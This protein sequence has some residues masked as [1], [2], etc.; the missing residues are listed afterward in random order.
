MNGLASQIFLMCIPFFIKVAFWFVWRSWRSTV[1]LGFMVSVAVA[2]LVFLS[3]LAVGTNDAMVRNS[4]GLYSGHISAERLSHGLSRES[5]LVSGVK[6]VLIRNSVQ[7]W[8]GHGHSREATVL[9]GVDPTE[10]RRFT[11]LW[12]K[13]SRGRYLRKEDRA[14]F[15]SEN[16]AHRLGVGVGARVKVGTV[17]GEWIGSLTVCGL[18]RTG[19][20]ALDLGMAFCTMDTLP[21]G[22]GHPSAAVFLQDGVGPDAVLEK[23]GSL[24]GSSAF[25][26]WTEFMPDLK[27]L[28]DL[29]YLSMGIVMVLVFGV[30]SLGISCA[31]V[32]FI[33]KS[34]REH[35]I[36]KAMGVL[37]AESSCMIAAQILLLTLTASLAGVIVGALAVAGFSR[38]GIDLGAWTSYNPYLAVSGVIFPRLTAYSLC[39]P[40]VLALGF[41]LFAAV[42]PSVFI[43]R[44]RA[45]EILRS[46]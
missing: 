27:Q 13:A 25:R 36:M 8:L 32:I 7:V 6:G 14:I 3:S 38:V 11:A 37:P 33:L 21:E 2:A 34:I 45:A 22:A 42:W 26:A 15:L 39:V 43:I 19:I 30:V 46:T 17:P 40:P 20:S 12:K 5:L 23:Y 24:A 41:G 1:V 29:N 31:F 10:E 16:V 9:T 44:A 35:G 18:F 4:V 28:I